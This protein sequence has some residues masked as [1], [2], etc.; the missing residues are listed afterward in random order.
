MRRRRAPRFEAR[1]RT[2]QDRNLQGS[3]QSRVLRAAWPALSEHVGKED[4]A[5]KCC[6]PELSLKSLL[7]TMLAKEAKIMVD[8]AVE[9]T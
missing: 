6:W 4:H 2:N 1:S 3:A 7:E 5:A 9:N 8:I